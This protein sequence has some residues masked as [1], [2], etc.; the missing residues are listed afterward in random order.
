MHLIAGGRTHQV[1]LAGE[2]INAIVETT[3]AKPA[4]STTLTKAELA[5]ARL[6]T[7]GHS[8]ARISRER[9]V[10]I[11]TVANQ[12][13]SI[14]SKLRIGSRSELARVLREPT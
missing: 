3:A 14:Y 2:T 7:R 11:R 13:A 5:V 8:N 10:S 4:P 9:G 1:E 12:L 6:A